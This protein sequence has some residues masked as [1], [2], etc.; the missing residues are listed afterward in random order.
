MTRARRWT[1]VASLTAT[2]AAGVVALVTGDRALRLDYALQALLMRHAAVTRLVVE[3]AGEIPM[4][5]NPTDGVI[6]PRIMAGLFEPSETQATVESLR[7]GDTFVDVGANVGYYT[8]LAARLV[9]QEGRVFA[10]EPDPE[11]FA[12]LER[13]VRLNGFGN[14]VLEPK[15]VSNEEGKLRLYLSSENKGDH[16]IYQVQGEERPFVEV[17]V[18]TL[19]RYFEGDPG[20][21]DFVKI[22]TQGADLAVI[23]GMREILE[24]HEGILLSVEFWPYGLRDFGDEASDLLD[25]V[26]ARDF[27]LFDLRSG[28]VGREYLLRTYGMEEYKYTNLLLVKGRGAVEKLR[29][30]VRHWAREVEAND[31]P[32]ARGALR[33][34]Q[35]AL[36]ALQ[37]GAPNFPHRPGN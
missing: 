23:E 28:E 3:H 22:D 9:G 20:R 24:S 5:L 31:S 37:P 25:F 29:S 35:R 13:N 15:A 36:R 11:S 21:I 2:L 8:L 30:E 1:V 4:F 19:D 34:A 26:I 16:R 6:T 10:F 32:T 27:R 17:E 33:R 12:L 14:V 18:V 7:R